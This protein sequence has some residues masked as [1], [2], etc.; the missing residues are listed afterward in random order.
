VTKLACELANSNALQEEEERRAE[1]E[2]DEVLFT[3]SRDDA[4]QVKRQRKSKTRQLLPLLMTCLCRIT[5]LQMGV[6]RVLV[7]RGPAILR[8]TVHI[9]CS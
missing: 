6:L 2:E 5:V 9:E 4:Y 3:Y 1:L 8:L 7:Y